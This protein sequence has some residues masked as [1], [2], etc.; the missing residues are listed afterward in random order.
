MDL[1]KPH[2][3]KSSALPFHPVQMAIV[4]LGLISGVLYFF[5]FRLQVFF[6]ENHLVVLSGIHFYVFLLF[7]GSRHSLREC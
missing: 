5:N 4:G 2:Q 7:T 1:E 6:E 3:V